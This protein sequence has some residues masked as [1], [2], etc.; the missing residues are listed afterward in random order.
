MVVLVRVFTR[1]PAA[2]TRQGIGAIST[3]LDV[4]TSMTLLDVS[5]NDL[6]VGAK[7]LVESLQLNNK[8]LKT[9]VLGEN[10]VDQ[11][12]RDYAVS[13]LGGRVAFQL[14]K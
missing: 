14:W 6:N 4:N 7:R 5:G 3:A 13:K 8:T 1:S 10:D 11:A 2:G 12:F 9:L